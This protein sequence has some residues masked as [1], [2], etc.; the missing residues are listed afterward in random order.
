[1]LDGLLDILLKAGVKK[2]ID[3]RC[4]PVARRFGFTR[5]HGNVTAGTLA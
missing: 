2:L 5:A 3:V 1:M 4:N